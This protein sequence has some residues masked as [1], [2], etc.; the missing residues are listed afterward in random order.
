MNKI[1]CSNCGTELNND[2]KFCFKCGKQVNLN[3]VKFEDEGIDEKESVSQKLYKQYNDIICTETTTAYV[4]NMNLGIENLY[5]KGVNYNF[6]KELVDKVIAEQT[7]KINVFIKYLKSLYMDG[8]L[9]MLDTDDDIVDE[10][11][12]YALNIGLEEDDADLI[13]EN[14]IEINMIKEKSDVLKEQLDCY[15]M[16]GFITE[17]EYIKNTYSAIDNYDFYIEFIKKISELQ[18]FQLLL[19]KQSD[20]IEL[21]QND[22]KAV[23]EKAFEMGFT[24]WD[25]VYSYIDG[26]EE[27]LGFANEVRIKAFKSKI[28]KNEKM[29]ALI[30][31][32]KE[33]TIF[34][35]HVQFESSLFIRE[36]IM[37]TVIENVDL[38]ASDMEKL[39]DIKNKLNSQ[40]SY[41][42][43]G[44]YCKKIID[45]RDNV[46]R[47][48]IQEL[49]IP[50]QEKDEMRDYANDKFRN[51]DERFPEILETLAICFK[52]LD[53][54]VEDVKWQNELNKNSRGRWVG[55]GFGLQ[56]AV[57]GAVT[58]S[59]LNAGTGLIY[60]SLNGISNMI[61]RGSANSQKKKI[62]GEFIKETYQYLQDVI[63][64]ITIFCLDY[65]DSNYELQFS[66]YKKTFESYL[67]QKEINDINAEALILRLKAMPYEIDTYETL[68]KFIVKE[69][70]IE[71]KADME[72]LITVAKWFDID[73]EKIRNANINFIIENFNKDDI[74][75]C[76]LLYRSEIA[77]NSKNETLRNE[78]FNEYLN[79]ST[80]TT[81]KVHTF[82]ELKNIIKN[83]DDFGLKYEYLID[84]YKRIRV[85]E[86]IDWHFENDMIEF[87][88]E[89]INV[90]AENI[91][92]VKQY[93][94]GKYL[95]IIDNAEKKIC[96]IPIKYYK[97]DLEKS[98]I[99]ELNSF[100]EKVKEINSNCVFD[101]S[102]IIAEAEKN[103]RTVG[104]IEYESNEDANEARNEIA[105][106]NNIMSNKE[107]LTFSEKVYTI[108]KYQFKSES[109]KQCINDLEKKLI[110]QI[111]YEKA[112]LNH[113]TTVGKLILYLI[114]TPIVG[115]I[116]CMFGWKGIIVGLFII[117]GM[118]SS[119]KEAV[120]SAKEHN[121]KII[122]RKLNI[123][124]FYMLFIIKDDHLVP[125]YFVNPSHNGG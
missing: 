113:Q 9:L 34:G 90:L 23:A 35:I 108:M 11:I 79:S 110:S 123:D 21:T 91:N 62:F 59:V 13:Y 95:D 3:R 70:A 37:N 117:V 32:I 85:S 81:L 19:H 121:E 16:N 114:L 120:C 31:P 112:N 74:Q 36:Y 29:F 78:I 7:E 46:T 20:S 24:N 33:I 125:K 15:R 44:K 38:I 105:A 82:D 76:D 104:G 72:A 30:C 63:E 58:S 17:I 97:I 50:Q 49:P 68:A 52:E 43:I 71:S 100:I 119:Y 94:D 25:D 66:E 93:Y 1:F 64:R 67:E 101:F 2:V 111:Q 73:E 80:L 103:K 5:K 107:I 39:E 122:V 88:A 60:S 61:A 51:F 69:S 28:D 42:E 86:F 65:I 83:I 27:A 75:K 6:S 12:Q 54:G 89:N 55:G 26:A 41:L 56:G 124:R 57:K 106:I 87:S 47:I 115:V 118:W 96:L 98:N 8:S 18:E 92:K 99:T 14:F 116:S 102:P 4:N 77:F 84:E 48:I 22:K 45:L 10:C 53:E 109:A 40:S